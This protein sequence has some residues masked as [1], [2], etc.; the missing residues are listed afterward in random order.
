MCRYEM[1]E[2]QRSVMNI[3]KTYPDT[4]IC[5]IGGTMAFEPDVDMTL[6]KRAVAIFIEQ[7]PSMRLRID[8]DDMLY[9]SNEVCSVKEC[10]CAD[11]VDEYVRKA[12]SRSFNIYNAP[13]YDFRLIKTDTGTVGFMKIHHILGDYASL[14]RLVNATEK[15]YLRLREGEPI[16]QKNDARYIDTMLAKKPTVT[17][18]A[19]EYYKNQFEKNLP[20]GSTVRVKNPESGLYIHKLSNSGKLIDFCKSEN[21][22]LESIFY[23]AL[24]FYERAAR[25]NKNVIIGRVLMNRGRYDINTIG[26]YANTVP[27]FINADTDFRAMCAAIEKTLD[28]T[29]E[30]GSYPLNRMLAD[31]NIRERCFNIE[32]SYISKG[33]MPKLKIA[34]LE[35]CFSG[36]SEVPI[37]IHIIRSKQ[38]IELDI[39]YVRERYSDEYIRAFTAALESILTSV[40][41]GNAPSVLTETDITMYRALNIVP[42]IE[43]DTTVSRLFS[44]GTKSHG[45]ETAVIYGGKRLSFSDVE[46]MA[47]CI[48]GKC[49]G[50][51]IVGIASERCEYLIPAMLGVLKA[52]AAY[53]PINPLIDAP[54]ECDMLLSLSKYHMNGAVM[55]DKLDYTGGTPIDLSKPSDAAYYMRTSG[56]SGAPKTVMISN[57]SLYLRLRWMHD[58]YSLKGTIL[59]KTNPTF[60][61][62]GWELLCGAFGGQSVLMKDG[63]EKEPSKII[64]YINKYG[65]DT[66]HFVPSMLRLFLRFADE[67]PSLKNVFSSGEALDA[68]TVHLFYEKLPRVSLHN[69]YGPTECTIDVTSYDCI[70]NEMEIPIGKPV[71]NTGIYIVNGDFEIVPIGVEGEIVV[72]GDLVG[73]GYAEG[74]GGYTEL[75]E[76]RAYRTGDMGYLGF[77]GNVYYTGRRDSQIKL[78]G[79][80]IDLTEIENLTLN[81]DGVTNAAAIY[82]GRRVTV[83]YTADKPIKDITARLA[84]K[85]DRLPS[86]IVH[87]ENMPT[88]SNGKTDR[89]A[90]AKIKTVQNRTPAKNDTERLIIECA[91]K[92]L[93]TALG[94]EDNFFDMGLDSLSALSLS[95]SL[96][97]RGFNVSAREIY[98]NPTAR[99]LAEN[100][101]KPR[102]L[103]R[104]NNAVSDKALCCFPYAGG[105]PYAFSQ[106]AKSEKREV[107]GVNY[108][109]FEDEFDV[110]KIS[111]RIAEELTQYKTVCIASVCIGSA[112]ALETAAALEKRG[113]TVEALYISA[114]LPMR[115]PFGMNPW[116]L[117]TRKLIKGMLERLLGDTLPDN[118]P[119][120]GFLRDTDRYFKYMATEKPRLLAKAYIA[121]ADKDKFT[122]GY[123]KKKKRWKAYFSELPSF[124]AF[125]TDNHYFMI[126][127][128][129][130]L[131]LMEKGESDIE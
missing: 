29:A 61:V 2:Y 98:E 32:V 80:R 30:C 60:D 100:T 38:E 129:N 77:D 128:E 121:F 52:G 101:N 113:L 13:L 45:S 109:F 67:L 34:K 23:S 24:A 6:I 104:L 17:D 73:I 51:K 54:P 62:S 123:K 46:R 124:S 35:R 75:M 97:G 108:D 12:I 84:K 96:E 7:N 33:M 3:E 42:Y 1:N 4:P 120:N 16:K 116:Q 48:A 57:G 82:D 114:S 119:L 103:V 14:L 8:N 15:I 43:A 39:E 22:K 26:L 50:K 79:K 58:K 99:M 20:S 118:M 95:L 49:V 64:E 5:C 93:K 72:C 127:T 88:L 31:N 91:E 126:K 76:K 105:I 90:L 86:R 27:V 131:E 110:R 106:M 81:I 125:T 78:N 10:E 94:A 107:L 59:Q 74:K 83:F 37:R 41:G 36:F 66:I 9:V 111:A 112:F 85:S 44:E 71:Y 68:P 92:E 55:L 70:G 130:I 18:N 115:T 47:N 87:I 102:M 53:M 11:D 65:V 25:G 63:E 28:K 40:C 89:A 19:R 56:S 69:L 21:I 122:K 117:L